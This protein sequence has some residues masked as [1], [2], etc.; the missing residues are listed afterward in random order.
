MSIGTGTIG[1]TASNTQRGGTSTGGSSSAGG[2]SLGIGDK[3][4]DTPASASLPSDGVSMGSPLKRHRPSIGG[5]GKE[6]GSGLVGSGVT[7]LDG[8][9]SGAKEAAGKP[10]SGFGPMSSQAMEEEEL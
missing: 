8:L 6:A 7:G 4:V 9:L 5:L 10:E 2:L 1:G 3:A